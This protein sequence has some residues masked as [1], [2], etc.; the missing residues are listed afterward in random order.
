MYIYYV[1]AYLRNKDS[2]NGKKGTPYYIGKGKKNR[3]YQPH[4]SVP[5]PKDKNN[6]IFL[7]I[8]L[9]ELGAF[10]IER[11]MI[12]WYSRKDLGTGILSN[13]TDG[14]E[15]SSGIIPW[16]KNKSGY[17]RRINPA[18]RYQTGPA[19]A[20]SIKKRSIA[21]TGQK[22]SAQ[23]IANLIFARSLEDR[24]NGN[25]S[26]AKS[27]IAISPTNEIFYINRGM[28]AD[29]CNIQNLCYD[30]MK[31]LARKNQIGKR[32]ICRDWKCIYN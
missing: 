9:S 14:G 27:Y 17:S 21:L 23:S 30:S 16:N 6:I 28:L 29:F 19:S 25:N 15:G 26:N 7:E 3:A 18:Q 32:G 2:K 22:R 31:V 11:R 5:V 4:G 10:A 8:H 24:T 12:R 13:Q 1:Y 20:D